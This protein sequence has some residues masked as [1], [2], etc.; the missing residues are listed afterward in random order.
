M[1]T[2]EHQA[3]DRGPSPAVRAEPVTERS[4][5][6]RG[7]SAGYALDV[8]RERLTFDGWIAAVGTG[9]GTRV[10][11]GHWPRSPF[12]PFSWT[13]SKISRPTGVV[14]GRLQGHASE[15]QRG[16]RSAAV[17]ADLVDA[18]AGPGLREIQAVLDSRLDQV[19]V[20]REHHQRLLAE[21]PA[22]P[23]RG[24]RRAGRVRHV[25]HRHTA[26]PAARG[27]PRPRPRPRPGRRAR[28]R[29]LITNQSTVNALTS[30]AN[31]VRC[32]SVSVAYSG[33]CIS[34]VSRSARC[35][36]GTRVA[37]TGCGSCQP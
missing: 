10:V 19:A 3:R 37:A 4:S 7:R 16:G 11:V 8:G 34:S 20:L 32:R 31:S 30:W 9:S 26:A 14:R 18:G 15:P 21:G 27:R 35:R 6:L 22:P 1:D 5:E 2:F 36:R 28:P 24:R 17:A 12:G 13:S 23:A 25:G 33:A 29:Q